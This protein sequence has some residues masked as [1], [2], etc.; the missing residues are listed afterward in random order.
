M[1][2]VMAMV[3]VVVI[4]AFQLDE[5]LTITRMEVTDDETWV[6]S[7]LEV[8]YLKLVLAVEEARVQATMPG[9]I[10]QDHLSD[11]R[12]RFDI[13]YS[14][15][16]T[17][18]SKV[19]SWATISDDWD[20]SLQQLDN[21]II[22]RDRIAAILD[23][24]TALNAPIDLATLEAELAAAGNDARD[25]SVSALYILSR[26]MTDRRLSYITEFR[27]LLLQTVSMVLVMLL[28]SIA[29]WLLYR[30]I[31]AR[32]AAERR[33]SENLQRVF[34]AKPD[35]I[36]LTDARHGILRMNTAASE[37]FGVE[38]AQAQ[39]HHALDW[40]FP[41]VLRRS[42]RGGTHPLTD[43][44]RTEGTFTYRDIVR[45]VSGT[46]AVEVTRIRL[47][48][49]S[50]GDTIAL[51]VRDISETQRALRALRRERGRAEAEA[52][53]Y[54]RFLSVMSHEIRSPLHAIIASLDLARQR[55]E[56]AALDDLHGIAM[57]AAEVALEEADAVLDI[58]RAEH[59]MGAAEPAVF[60]PAE[61][62]RDLVEMTGPAA[63]SA[64]TTL[65]VEIAPEA[66]ATILGL[67]ACFWHAVSNL[68]SNAVK[69]TRGGT[70]RLRLD[71][72][73]GL[74]RVE[75]TDEGPGIAPELQNV[76]FRDHYTRDPVPGGRGKGAGLGLGLFV[77]AVEAL[78]GQY[79][80][81]SAPDKGSTFWFTFP[82]PHAERP[83]PADL[84]EA[85]P[86][87]AP[88]PT[89]LR[90]LV[91]D[92]SHVN[93]TL[94]RQMFATLGL[95]ADLATSGVEAVALAQAFAYDLILMD[96]SMPDMDGYAAAAAIR[97]AGASRTATIVALTANVLA[98]PEV[99]KPGTAFDD[100][101]LK[102]LRL[103]ALRHAL[104]SGLR[105]HSPALAAMPPLIDQ[106]I[107]RDLLEMLPAAAIKPLLASLFDEAKGVAR[108]LDR[109]AACAA[110]ATSFHRI[111]GSAGMLG[112]S[113]LRGLALAAEAECKGGNQR[114]GPVFRAAWKEA[115]TDTARDWADLLAAT[116]DPATASTER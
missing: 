101:W 52:A 48:A 111:A 11:V 42:L 62:A 27:A 51:F 14:R 13:F 41:G 58:G 83:T 79:G 36:L 98:R 75:V 93:R 96:L 104:A 105:H 16:A 77:A 94:V 110:L 69:F 54:Q 35:A 23:A 115:V 25:L 99:D 2:I 81:E 53:R 10:R 7:Q 5:L 74:L 85:A 68:L 108:D 70:V 76:I 55:P 60:S 65:S 82:A 46:R 103:D 92:D 49:E 12:H 112:A 32:A 43:A 31:G 24:P 91:V 30:Q 61:I 29:A 116:A 102:P 80:L 28:T 26:Q 22:H 113:R 95:A 86:A 59:E 71:R 37:L 100:L 9:G 44:A 88:L 66:E 114:P 34:D 84:L 45:T 33:L 78:G 87:P 67:R 19:P 57:D 20:R 64:G 90:I 39:G 21:L 107:A 106:P 17:V 40:F 109:G 89:G 1:L 63:H 3:P 72:Q 8:D 6:I 47:M 15:I 4:R 97:E 38:E 18:S 50:G 56:S 73:D